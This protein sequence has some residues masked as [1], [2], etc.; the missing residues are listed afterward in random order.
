MVLIQD[1]LS[2]ARF[3]SIYY[4]ARL[5]VITNLRVIHALLNKNSRAS[6]P[7]KLDGIG[8][9]EKYYVV[10]ME[11][12][13]NADIIL[14][15]QDVQ[16]HRPL[17]ANQLPDKIK[18]ENLKLDLTWLEDEIKMRKIYEI[19]DSNQIKFHAYHLRPYSHIT[20][21]QPLFFYVVKFTR[22]TLTLGLRG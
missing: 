14:E 8:E 10:G 5:S 9:L 21:K 1:E 13:N 17:T 4:L 7:R 18:F 22:Q 16:L 2:W 6:S 11:M 19:L 15:W 20:Q 12:Q 3:S